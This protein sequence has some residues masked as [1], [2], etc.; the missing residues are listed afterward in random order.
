LQVLK[1]AV[2]GAE[3]VAVFWRPEKNGLFLGGPENGHFWV[4]LKIPDFGGPDISHHKSPDSRNSHFRH[5]YNI[6]KNALIK[7]N[8][9]FQKNTIFYIGVKCVFLRFSYILKNRVKNA[10]MGFLYI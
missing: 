1:I 3:K 5:F 9:F 7:K 2:F 10:K 6:P 8:F 4:V